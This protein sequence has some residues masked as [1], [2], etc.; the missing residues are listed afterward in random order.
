MI[1]VENIEVWGFEHALRGMRNPLNSWNRSDSY[2]TH[3][4]DSETLQ[5]AKFEFFAGENDLDLMRRLYKAG[6]E[7]RKFLRQ[8]FVSMDIIAPRFWFLEFD[9]YKIGTVSNSCS[10]MHTIMKKPFTLEDFSFDSSI[11]FAKGDC[12]NLVETLNI[13]RELYLL[14]DVEFKSDLLKMGYKEDK[15]PTK[16]E[17]WRT[18]I[19]FLPQSYNQ[20][21]TVTMNYENVFNMIHQRENHK[22]SEWRYFTDILK[23]LPYVKEIAEN[24]EK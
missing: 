8:I 1:K 22:L 13:L 4:E 23:N 5:T 3:I 16:Q 10:T 6:A 15:I 2:S 18:L 9:T 19:E 24:D 20:R 12:E 11:P 14:N 7:H 17:I 21:R